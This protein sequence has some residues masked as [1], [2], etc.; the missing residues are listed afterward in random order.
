MESV[1]EKFKL[2]LF[3]DDMTV[4]IADL[5]ESCS[6]ITTLL[7]HNIIKKSMLPKIIYRFNAISVKIVVDFFE[8][9]GKL[10]LKFR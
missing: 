10:F 1:K 7:G 8:E 4:Y 2:P 6:W 3:T 9:T 5:I